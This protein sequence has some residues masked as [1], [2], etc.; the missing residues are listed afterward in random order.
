MPAPPA[1]SPSRLP[2]A[3]PGGIVRPPHRGRTPRPTACANAGGRTL[4][5]VDARLEP[6]R[7]DPSGSAILLDIDGTLAPTVAHP[8]DSAVPAATLEVIGGLVERY[9]LVACVSGRTVE[10][11]RRLVP[12]EGV[13]FS[14]NH[15]LELLVAGAVVPVPAAEAHATAVAAAAGRLEA[16]VAGSGGWI[17]DKRLTLTLHYRQSPDIVAAEQLIGAQARKVAGELGLRCVPGRM[18]FEIR[19]PVE[20]DKG[21][22]V[23]GLVATRHVSRSL[24]A[25][26]DTTDIDAF[27]VVDVSVAVDSVEAPAGLR[28]AA[29]L[30]V[31]GPPG[32]LRLLSA[33]L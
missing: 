21:T 18:S 33:L 27:A 12:V 10:E 6:F 28:A 13:A 3:D 32:L 16:V 22:A 7:T 17:E 4:R 23:R 15:G 1:L 26:D 29:T 20:A 11:A 2:G 31:D 24:Y 5:A 9:G 25:G 8:S 14:G 30:A 19:P